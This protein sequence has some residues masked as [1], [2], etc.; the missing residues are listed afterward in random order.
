MQGVSPDI[1]PEPIQPDFAR[2]RSG[3]SHLKHPRGDPQPSIRRYHLGTSHPLGE[4]TSFSCRQPSSVNRVL[5]IE[6]IRFLA[7]SISQCLRSSEMSKK[8]AVSGKDV[9]LIRGAFLVL[10]ESKQPG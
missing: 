4:L 10:D 6:L 7:R 9:E 5:P 8:V 2:R 1:P 3:T